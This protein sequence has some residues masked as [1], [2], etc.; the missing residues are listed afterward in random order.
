MALAQ[1]QAQAAGS[2]GIEKTFETSNINK[3]SAAQKVT[4]AIPDWKEYPARTT[5]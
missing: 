2:R 4:P 1:A 5:D 3:L